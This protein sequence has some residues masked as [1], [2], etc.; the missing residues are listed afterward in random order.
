MKA[1]S[2][3]IWFI[4]S[5]FALHRIED[6]TRLKPE[7]LGHMIITPVQFHGHVI[8]KLSGWC[9]VVPDF[10]ID[11]ELPSLEVQ[12]GPGDY[13]AILSLMNSLSDGKPTT[14]PPD[15]GVDKGEGDGGGEK[16]EK[17]EEGSES[18]DT[19]APDASD[20]ASSSYVK[21]LMKFSMKEVT[22]ALYCWCS[23]CTVLLRLSS[24]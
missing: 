18:K 23:H 14:P 6:T 20:A 10:T 2:V 9:S 12:L 13:S 24:I 11:A 4:Y 15:K 16:E 3:P 22:L 1:R 17:E 21:L 7:D 19:E 8:R 5:H